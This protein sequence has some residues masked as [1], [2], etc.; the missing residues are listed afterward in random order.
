MFIHILHLTILFFIGKSTAF[1]H[2]SIFYSFLFGKL[3]L[4]VNFFENLNVVFLIQIFSFSRWFKVPLWYFQDYIGSFKIHKL[5]DYFL[6]K[7]KLIRVLIYTWKT[8]FNV[9]MNMQY[10]RL[11]FDYHS[12]S[13]ITWC[14]VHIWLSSMLIA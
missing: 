11:K 8:F 10:S 3:I 6:V 12:I 7:F 5:F 2:E 13:F 14:K 1:V 9:Q 4:V